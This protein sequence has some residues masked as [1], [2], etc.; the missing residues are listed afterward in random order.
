M[1]FVIITMFSHLL[2]ITEYFTVFRFL[3]STLTYMLSPWLKGIA[4]TATSML[5]KPCTNERLKI[6]LQ[7]RIIIPVLV[8]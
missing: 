4:P 8:I 2:K 7:Y 6:V 5:P 1:E 3:M